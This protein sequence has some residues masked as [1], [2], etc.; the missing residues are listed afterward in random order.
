MT[1]SKNTEALIQ[2]WLDKA[3]DTLGAVPVLL[4]EGFNTSAVNRLYYA[5]FYGV[6]ALLLKD[7]R[8]FSKH[9]AVLAEFNHLYVKVGKIDK[10]W[11]RFLKDL[12]RD[13]QE[14]D[15]LPTAT[16]ETEEIQQRLEQAEKFIATIR[17]LIYP[18]KS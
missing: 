5:C 11:S 7:G 18:V 14:S 4:H 6:T 13:R 16:F 8:Q 1:D 15:Y 17:A 2:L 10:E 12:F 3:T 9:S